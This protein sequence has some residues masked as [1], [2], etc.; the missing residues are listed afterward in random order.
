M[1]VIYG[2]TPYE[3]MEYSKRELYTRYRL[4]TE[5]YDMIKEECDQ[6]WKILAT[7]DINFRRIPQHLIP[8]IERFQHSLFELEKSLESTLRQM[9]L[10]CV[11]LEYKLNTFD[12]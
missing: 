6:A 5:R 1:S 10:V 2:I 7:V 8:K 4:L 12:S 11:T 3:A 9:D